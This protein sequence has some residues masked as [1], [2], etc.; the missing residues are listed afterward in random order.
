[1]ADWCWEMCVLVFECVW[2]CLSGC[3]AF[4]Y[5]G[6]YV[7]GDLTVISHQWCGSWSTVFLAPQLFL[8]HTAGSIVRFSFHSLCVCVLLIQSQI[9]CLHCQSPYCT[10]RQMLV[11]VH[12]ALPV[13]IF[14]S[15]D[16]TMNIELV[17]KHPSKMFKCWDLRQRQ[18]RFCGFPQHF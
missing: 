4:A 2:L 7:L 3:E 15:I 17:S 1:M 18:S 16:P 12:T 8:P 6:P 10:R 11:C 13:S 5:V 14:L 9:P